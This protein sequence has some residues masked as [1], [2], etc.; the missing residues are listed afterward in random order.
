MWSFCC[1]KR[2]K[3]GGN[4]KKR[5]SNLSQMHIK[6]GGSA[7]EFMTGIHN[8]QLQLVLANLLI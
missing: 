5:Q 2:E 6:R 8:L 3:R 1:D 7:A 4:A